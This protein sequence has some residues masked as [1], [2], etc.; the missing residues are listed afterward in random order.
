M[1]CPKSN[2]TRAMKLNQFLNSA[3]QIGLKLATYLGVRSA[4][5]ST[6]LRSLEKIGLVKRAELKSLCENFTRRMVAQLLGMFANLAQRR[7]SK[8]ITRLIEGFKSLQSEREKR[9]HLKSTC[10]NSQSSS[11]TSPETERNS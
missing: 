6:T 7:I 4:A 8:N 1:K 9:R 10:T 11:D 3:A 2:A 5:I